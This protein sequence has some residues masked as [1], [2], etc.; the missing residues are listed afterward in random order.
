MLDALRIPAFAAVV[1]VPAYLLAPQVARG[2]GE[3]DVAS[4]P[5]VLLILIDDLNDW[6]SCLDGHP[7]AV[8]PNLDR[9]ARRGTLFANAHCQAPLCNP[10]RTSFL[11]GLRPSTTGVYALDAWFRSSER[12]ADHETLPQ[13]FANRGYR[14]IT[15]GKVFHDAYPP[16]EGRADGAEFT[17]WGYH[18]GFQPLPER[19]FVETPDPIRLMDWGVY[20]EHDEQQDDWKIADWAIEQ[21]GDAANH[22]EPLFLSVGF[23]HPHVPCYAT[24]RWFDLYPESTLRLPLAPADDR[25]DVPRFAWYLHWRLPEPRLGWLVESEQWAP[26]VRAYLASISFVDDQVGRMLDALD[27]SGLAGNTVVA[28]TS[29]HGYH[30]G[31]KGV[32]G[33]NTLWEPSTRVPLILAGPGVTAG[34]VCARSAELVD[35]YPTLAELCG[36][37]APA[38]LDGHS[39]APQL[40]AADSP[41][42]Q[43]AI[44]TH[45]PGNH[46]IRT[47]RWRFIRYADG[48]EELYDLAVDPDELTNLATDAAHAE[49]R[50]DLA[51][52]I[53]AEDAAPLPGGTL[54]LV[55]LREGIVYWEGKPLGADEAIPD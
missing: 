28:L 16:P 52:W 37:P 6:V 5:N 46:G 29:D 49:T 17:V 53:P 43:P 11:T 47:E 50:S 18:G 33:K 55:E 24:Q 12:W 14:T 15:T 48:S 13:Y 1:L 45:G 9:L 21:L 26:L 38:G 2:Q 44:T 51:R 41:R 36:L 4:R 54:R 31:E 10:S 39:L 23:R 35:L 3:N 19:K 32:S 34:A 22:P 40:R 27:A 8:T 30:L 20:P 42:P 25:D 7:R